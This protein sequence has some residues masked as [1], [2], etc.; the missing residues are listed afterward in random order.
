MY[1]VYSLLEPKLTA[2]ISLEISENKINVNVPHRPRRDFPEL[3]WL[4]PVG[5]I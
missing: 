1:R 3:F 5:N 4:S 2:V